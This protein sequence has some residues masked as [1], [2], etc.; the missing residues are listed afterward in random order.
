MFVL[1]SSA[2]IE[3]LRETNAGRRIVELLKDEPSVTTSLCLHEVLI[4][5]ETPRERF[6]VE[7]LCSGMRIL[8][9]ESTSGQ[10]G[11]G[12]ERDLRKRGKII[13]RTDIMIAAICKDHNAELITL[14][15]D[16]AGITALKSRIVQ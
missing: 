3:I 1:D 9:H 2:I 14:D 7:G 10:I 15:K 8:S 6:V 11:A 12:I 4:G 16:F 13:G 5:T